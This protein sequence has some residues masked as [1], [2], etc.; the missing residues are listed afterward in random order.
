MEWVLEFETE[1]YSYSLQFRRIR[2]KDQWSS[3]H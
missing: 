1:V 2:S 3:V